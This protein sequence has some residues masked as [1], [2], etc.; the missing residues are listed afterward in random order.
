MSDRVWL[1]VHIPEQNFKFDYSKK[2]WAEAVRTNK[3][4]WLIDWDISD[5]NIDMEYYG[6]DGAR[7]FPHGF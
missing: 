2:Q 5:L 3:I 6:P 1:R 7:I 4:D